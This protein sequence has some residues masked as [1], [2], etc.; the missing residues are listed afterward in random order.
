MVSVTCVLKFTQPPISFCRNSALP[1]CLIERLFFHSVIVP[2]AH[3]PSVGSLEGR[4]WVT[5]WTLTMTITN[6][7][8]WTEPQR[9]HKASTFTHQA[10]AS[11]R[12]GGG[13]W[14]LILLV[15]GGI[16]VLRDSKGPDDGDENSWAEAEQGLAPGSGL[17]VQAVPWGGCGV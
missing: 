12:H 2:R 14:L 15:K 4:R 6:M 10:C 16:S 7:R 13:H 1:R 5:P 9:L 17:R 3:I 11:Q 8:T